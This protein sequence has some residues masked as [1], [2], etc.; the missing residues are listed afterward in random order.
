MLGGAKGM[1]FMDWFDLFL[2]GFPFVLLIWLIAI[3]VKKKIIK[4][5]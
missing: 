3:K 2:H 1:Q 5:I 4:K